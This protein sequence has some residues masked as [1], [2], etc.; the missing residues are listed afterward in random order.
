MNNYV[1]NIL[2]PVMGDLII[3]TFSGIQKYNPLTDDFSLPARTVV[4][5]TFVNVVSSVMERKNE[6]YGLLLHL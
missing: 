6:K 4:D 2:K 3:C 1:K 5:E